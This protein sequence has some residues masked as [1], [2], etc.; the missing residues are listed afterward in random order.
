[1]RNPGGYAVITSP[2]QAR[3][4]FDKFRCDEISAGITEVDTFTC[5]HCAK[6]M[7]VK[8]KAPMDDVGSMCRNC[9]KMVCPRC[10]S[11]PCVPFLKKLELEEKRFQALRSYGLA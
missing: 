9:M 3:V 4:N 11:G 5:F 7:H 2:E 8:T 10:A 1:L 6:V